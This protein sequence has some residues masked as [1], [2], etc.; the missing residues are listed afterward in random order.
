MKLRNWHLAIVLFSCLWIYLSCTDDEPMSGIPEN[1]GMFLTT[2]PDADQRSGD[3]NVGLDYLL[4]GDYVKSGIPRGVYDFSLA[5][6]NPGMNELER[7]GN[8][9]DINF[10]YTSLVND[11]NIELVSPNCFQCHAGYADGQFIL[12]LGNT[13]TDF[14]NDQSA[15]SG[16]LDGL[17]E[18]NYGNPSAEWD[19][20]FPFSRAVRATGQHLVTETVGANPADKLALVL[21]AHRDPI[22]LSWIDEPQMIIP[23][24]LIPADVPAWW[25]L[26]KKSV[27]FSTGIGRGDF[28]K[29]MMASSI[30]TLE[31][32]TEARIIDEQF[33][34]VSEF[35]RNLE[36]PSYTG[37]I[38]M[39]KAS[40][41]E[42]LFAL[43]CATCHGT[44]GDSP[45][46]AT[47]LVAHD[48]IQTDPALAN[49]NYAYAEFESWFN[50]SWFG[51]DAYPA[52]LVPGD[53]YIAQ[54][55]DGIWATAPYLHNGSV[56]T[57]EDLLNS[58]QRPTYWRRSIDSEDYDHLKV[59]WDY[60]TETS[61]NSK[62]TYDTTLPGY[63]NMGHYFGDHLSQLDRSDLIEYLK[64]L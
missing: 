17:V 59:G 20:Y 64:T 40:R 58:S 33:I 52:Q 13:A 41:G 47:K 46:Y 4:Y 26:K 25:L 45:S 56:P 24:E 31:D 51:T 62:F 35:I 43:N 6:A 39:D 15:G 3:S 5:L 19:A 2:I 9:A 30:L 18:T 54:P 27:M 57:L 22:D 34:N 32:S 23:N 61:K 42:S 28:A 29:M 14:T 21:A 16:F 60:I 8:N 36:A 48:A 1:I 11:D 55:L 12:G 7:T 38:D 49:S 63:G 10:Q 44:Y 50:T 53:G 37:T